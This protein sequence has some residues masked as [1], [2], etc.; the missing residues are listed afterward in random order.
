M[1]ANHSNGRKLFTI[2]HEVGHY[3]LHAQNEEHY[4]HQ[5]PVKSWARSKEND[6]TLQK[7]ETE[8]NKF[9]AEILMP[10]DKFLELWS[11]GYSLKEISWEFGV[12]LLSCQYRSINLGL[13]EI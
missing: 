13:L 5:S 4:K 7:E 9:A 1:N 6:L 3:L 8:A 10:E 11:L 12:S 2:A